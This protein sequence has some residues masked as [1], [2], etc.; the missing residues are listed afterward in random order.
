MN[1]YGYIYGQPNRAYLSFYQ[2]APLA[3]YNSKPALAID[4]GK[5]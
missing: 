2:S 3:T 4:I 5:N 1:Y